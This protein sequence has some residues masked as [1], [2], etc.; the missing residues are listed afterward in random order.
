MPG[1]S[2]LTAVLCA[3]T[4]PQVQAGSGAVIDV[5]P[6]RASGIECIPPSQDPMT[7]DWFLAGVAIILHRGGQ[8]VELEAYIS[9]WD[10]N[11]L[12]IEIHAYQH[13]L[14]CDTFFSST[15]TRLIPISTDCTIGEGTF[16][17]DYCLGVDDDRPDWVY[18][19]AGGTLPACQSVTNC[20]DG[21]PG[22]F[23]CGAVVFGGSGGVD[24]GVPQYSSTFA[25]TIPSGSVGTWNVGLDQDINQTFLRDAMAA[26]IPIGENNPA[27]I[28][29]RCQESSQCDDGNECTTDSC[30]ALVGVCN[31]VML[32]EGT[33]CGSDAESACNAPD[34][35]D[36]TGTCNPN[37]EPPGT[38]CGACQ[39]SDVCD[40]EG[41]CGDGLIALEEYADFS[42][43]L[44]GPFPTILSTCCKSFDY[45]DD[46]DLDL[47]DF[48]EF[49]NVFTGK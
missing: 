26:E 43:C 44:T 23:A 36:N 47:L 6:I 40:E 34:T 39:E 29:V 31:N 35:C 18:A 33:A 9:G 45:D 49:Q 41:V 24:S 30:N 10:P 28:T 38:V 4:S 7:C 14:G 8:D 21:D 1:F 42:G 13:A 19:A 17:V 11:E 16:G 22:F 12:G 5:L 25:V 46:N 3:L 15:G 32:P 48:A 20:P 27:T 2:V 37:L